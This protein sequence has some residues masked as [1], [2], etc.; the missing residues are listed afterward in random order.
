MERA[1]LGQ[2][3]IKIVFFGDSITEGQY[4]DPSLRWTKIVGERLRSYFAAGTEIR[5]FNKGISGQTTRQALERYPA[6][7]Q[8]IVPDFL[9][10]Q[11]GLNDSNCWESDGGCNRVSPLAFQAN[12]LEMIDRARQFGVTRIAVC[13]N[14]RTLRDDAMISG[15]SLE[16]SNSMYNKLIREVSQESGIDL[17]DAAETFHKGQDLKSLLLPAPDKLHLS[18]VGH[19]RYASLMSDFLLEKLVYTVPQVARMAAS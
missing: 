17:F 1:I 10:I 8:D 3:T 15:M 9:T 12:L 6:D 16:A 19:R 14:H 4:V 11:F 2:G 13:T 5:S 18:E 7:V